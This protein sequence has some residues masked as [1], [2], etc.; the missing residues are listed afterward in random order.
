MYSENWRF[1]DIRSKANAFYVFSLIVLLSN[2]ELPPFYVFNFVQPDHVY[3]ERLLLNF[4]F[5]NSFC[6]LL[7]LVNYDITPSC[8]LHFAFG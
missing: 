7:F 8:F 3:P 6:E 4:P 5:S 1:S 2:P